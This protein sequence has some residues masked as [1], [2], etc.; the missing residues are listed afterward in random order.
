MYWRSIVALH[1]T[2]LAKGILR[3]RLLIRKQSGSVMSTEMANLSKG[4]RV[5]LWKA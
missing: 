4:Y 2:L 5:T 3:M 1:K